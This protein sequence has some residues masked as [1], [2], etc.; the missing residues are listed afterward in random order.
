MLDLLFPSKE[1]FF[2]LARLLFTL[3]EAWFEVEEGCPRLK[4]LMAVDGYTS[5]NLE[6]RLIVVGEGCCKLEGLIAMGG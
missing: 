4:R 2:N 1:V 5:L 6:R 3:D